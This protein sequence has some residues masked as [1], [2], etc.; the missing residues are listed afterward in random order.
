MQKAVAIMKDVDRLAQEV[1]DSPTGTQIRSL[2]ERQV[3][4]ELKVLLERLGHHVSMEKK[5]DQKAPGSHK[6]RYDLLVDKLVLLELK[7]ADGIS[8]QHDTQFQYY[9]HHTA[10]RYGMVVCFPTRQESGTIMIKAWVWQHVWLSNKK[11]LVAVH[12]F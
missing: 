6:G 4:I 7:R 12:D 8:P 3:Q 10:C 1:H 9:M 2:T 11:Q 5:V